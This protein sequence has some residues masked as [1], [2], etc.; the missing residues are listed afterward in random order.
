MS[1]APV[2][3][4]FKDGEEV[5]SLSLD[6]EAE[7]GRGEGCVIRLDDRAISRKHAVFRMVGNIVQVEKRSEFAPLSINGAE[8]TRAEVR[9][10]DVV[11]IG[12]Y[13]IRVK[14]E[15][16]AA[17]S[18]PV[19]EAPV[20]LQPAPGSIDSG[21]FSD[22][23]IGG[24]DFNLEPPPE[25]KSE[26]AVE[27]AISL[28]DPSHGNDADEQSLLDESPV[29]E[30]PASDPAP[31][32]QVLP[33]MD[34][35]PL[36]M[37]THVLPGADGALSEPLPVKP[38][39]TSQPIAEDAL[40][41]LSP[42]ERKSASIEIID[43]DAKTKL[44]SKEKLDVRLIF[45]VGA[46]NVQNFEI[47]ADE[48]SLGRGK[49]CDVVLNDKKS[50]RKNT[51]IR[52]AGGVFYIKD[53]DSANGTFVNGAK[54][55][56]MQLSGDDLIRV[57]DTE[58]QF[59]ILNSD[60]FAKEKDFPSLSSEK[61][62]QNQV[63][64]APQPQFQ[65]PLGNP[66]AYQFPQDVIQNPGPG[67]NFGVPAYHP[68]QAF[69]DAEAGGMPG[70]IPGFNP[71]APGFAGGAAQG[72]QSLV[73]KFRALPPKSQVI[74]GV[75][76]LVIASYVLDIL[77]EGNEA[78]KPNPRPSVVASGEPRGVKTFETLT[79]EEKQFVE[80]QHSL[81]YDY[82]TNKDYDKALVEVRK[83]FNIIPDYKDSRE[84]ERYA[85]EGQQKLLARQ[86]EI[87]EKEAAERL[88]AKIAQLVSETRD[89]ME[90]KQYEPAKELFTEIGLLDPDNVELTKWKKEVEDYEEQLKLQEQARQ[91]QAQNNLAGWDAYKEGVKLKSGGK[92]F[93]AI[94][95]FAQIPKNNVTDPKL[96]ASA[97]HQIAECRAAIQAKRDPIFA[98]AK[99]AEESGDLVKAFDLYRKLTVIDPTFG[100]GFAGMGRIKGVLHDRAKA[101]Y[102]E[103]V[104]AEGYSDFATARKK[105]KECLTVAPKDDVY[106]D[107][108][109]R[110]LARYFK[111]TGDEPPQ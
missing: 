99:Q 59:K 8:C 74:W 67:Q 46:A 73:Q 98:E 51:V 101:V 105:F 15:R 27:G 62:S 55:S 102:T 24:M 36:D 42:P 29:E 50:S 57:G 58:F 47:T 65:E 9:E 100:A 32:S 43:D 26:A 20:Q 90:K 10:G 4:I 17:Q 108:A 64:E 35:A 61:K 84:I 7:I 21:G 83:I 16:E 75:F 22:S 85:K 6:G 13:L 52:R 71:N 45:G 70:G 110:K 109:E 49:N 95:L 39:A 107:R 92:Y 103:A 53:L 96:L 11:S 82:F 97:K 18:K 5:K 14:M 86:K 34:M 28:G 104:L 91:I 89:K 23:P 48:V 79:A 41:G 31:P 69:Q 94:D 66:A 30:N 87:E 63:Y 80:S 54:I 38:I 19:Q 60:Y 78:P 81:A 56:E 106:H 1:A 111:Q 93:A 88:K 40:A 68:S 72:K 76:L 37:G 44:S 12:P 77:F 2:L 25:P 33:G 3:K